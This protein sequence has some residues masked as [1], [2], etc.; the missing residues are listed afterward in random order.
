MNGK[1]NKNWV[2]TDTITTTCQF[3]YLMLI[4]K[5]YMLQILERRA[6]TDQENK[7][8]S[9]SEVNTKLPKLLDT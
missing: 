4:G 5:S 3:S 9:I 8:G 6:F 7:V 2:L 1:R